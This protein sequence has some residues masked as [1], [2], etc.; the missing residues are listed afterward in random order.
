MENTFL[1]LPYTSMLSPRTHC[2]CVPGLSGF[3]L[4]TQYMTLSHPFRR[5]FQRDTACSRK[6]CYY[7]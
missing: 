7:S 2:N 5:M 1:L 3:L 6:N 4:N